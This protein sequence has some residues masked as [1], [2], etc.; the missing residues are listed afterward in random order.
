MTHLPFED[1]KRSL[2]SISMWVC[3]KGQF[4]GQAAKKHFIIFLF[5]FVCLFVLFVCLF[6]NLIP[7]NEHMCDE[8]VHIGNEQRQHAARKTN[9][10][11]I[12]KVQIVALHVA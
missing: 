5:C 2:F 9:L 8:K 12:F 4:L 7:G 3:E 10:E 11:E 6:G 1:E